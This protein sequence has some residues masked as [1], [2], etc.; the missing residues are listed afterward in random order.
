MV[1]ITKQ[2]DHGSHPQN[3]NLPSSLFLSLRPHSFITLFTKVYFHLI[4]LF[5]MELEYCNALK[6][7][8]LLI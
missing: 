5:R 3:Y 6:N 4:S 1:V 7:E 2:V 8:L